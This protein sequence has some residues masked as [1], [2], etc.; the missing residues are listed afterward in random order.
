MVAALAGGGFLWSR[1]YDPGPFV[2]SAGLWQR[3]RQLNQ[4]VAELPG[5]VMVASHPFIPVR[6]GKSTPQLHTMGY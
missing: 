1:R 4:L 2:P 6:N 3:A 5:G